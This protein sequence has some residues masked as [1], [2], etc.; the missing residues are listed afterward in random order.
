MRKTILLTFTL[1][2]N[3]AFAQDMSKYAPEL[4]NG[5]TAPEIC[6]Q[7]PEGKSISL[8][9]FKGKYVIIDF[10]ASWCGDCRREIPE[11]KKLYDEIKDLKLGDEKQGIEFLSVS[12]DKKKE[13][14]LKIL[15]KE[16]FPWTQISNLKNTREDP[17]YNAYKLH[18]I[19]TF[20]F[21]SPN[22]KVIASAI[23]TE[24]LRN[25]IYE[26][27]PLTVVNR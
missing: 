20:F 14:W 18:W 3:I 21:I 22:G 24:E 4:K 2:L 13:A 8:S 19:P 1:F 10:W 16:N 7:T 17:I 25:K 27:F 12:F 15:N 26:K 6:A 23:T 5:E 9:D 11:L